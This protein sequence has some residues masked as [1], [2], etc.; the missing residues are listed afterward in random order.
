MHHSV[1][2]IIQILKDHF[3]IYLVL[4]LVSATVQKTTP[5]HRGAD[6][7]EKYVLSCKKSKSIDIA[8][9]SLWKGNAQKGQFIDI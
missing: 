8:I 5:D 9:A 3:D 7:K 2:K 1:K 6:I 4:K